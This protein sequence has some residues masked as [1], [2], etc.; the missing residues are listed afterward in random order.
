M[1]SNE[2]KRFAGLLICALLVCAVAAIGRH[3]FGPR[4]DGAALKFT[5]VKRVFVRRARQRERGVLHAPLPARAIPDP[6]FRD[7]T[8]AVD[9]ARMACLLSIPRRRRPARPFRPSYDCRVLVPFPVGGSISLL[10]PAPT[11]PRTLELTGQRRPQSRKR[12]LCVSHPNLY[13]RQ[14]YKYLR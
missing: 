5:L 8:R 4:A 11:R 14:T 6:C 12:R 3:A 7:R 9:A 2:T 10:A 13:S 1:T